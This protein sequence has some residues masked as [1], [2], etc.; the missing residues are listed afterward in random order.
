MRQGLHHLM[1][2]LLFPAV[3]GT[4]FVLFVS[5]DLLEWPL[6]PRG[7][8]GL[9]FIAHWCLEFVLANQ[10]HFKARYSVIDFAGDLFL[11]VTMYN[12]FQA[13]P[14]S[15]WPRTD[16]YQGLYFWVMMVPVGFLGI[17]LA[18]WRFREQ[19]LNR[20]IVYV[21]LVVLGVTGVFW[22]LGELY[23]GFRQSSVVAYVFTALVLAMSIASFMARKERF[24]LAPRRLS[25]PLKS[26]PVDLREKP[27]LT[28]RQATNAELRCAPQDKKADIGSAAI[29]DWQT[30][31]EG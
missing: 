22:L 15:E 9:V 27:R 31:G 30:K 13:F 24:A 3:L 1:Y 20:A 18:S 17:N 16:G 5:E 10:N 2:G 26:V 8:F 23:L 14:D 6:G 4:L 7:S 21:D 29:T 11:I 12:A 28:V 25:P 19:K